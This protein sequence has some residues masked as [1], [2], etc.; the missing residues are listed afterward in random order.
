MRDAPL[1]CPSDGTRGRPSS[2]PCTLPAV[3]VRAGRLALAASWRA[4][5]PIGSGAHTGRRL[6]GKVPV[7]KALA[8]RHSHNFSLQKAIAMMA[9]AS[10]HRLQREGD[11]R[12]HV[13][14]CAK[15]LQE[16]IQNLILCFQFNVQI[17][18]PRIG[19]AARVI[20]AGAARCPARPFFWTG[21]SF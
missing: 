2:L 14:T 17:S 19:A 12:T 15:L 6:H 5:A 9:D 10:S 13:M 11:E 7:C 16:Y 20:K 4:A 18:V 1:P 21:T 8:S 3:L